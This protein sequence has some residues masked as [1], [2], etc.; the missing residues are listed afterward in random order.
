MLQLGTKLTEEQRIEKAV[1][2]IMHKVP[3]I[4]SLLM[5]GK[6]VVCDKT[7]T[8]CTNG[9]DEWYGRAFIRDLN[10]KQLRFL[11]LHEVYHKMYRHLITWRHLWKKCSNTANRAMDYEINIK[12]LDEFGDFVEWIEGGCLNEKYRGWGTAKIFN[13]IYEER[14]GGGNKSDGEGGAGNGEGNGTGDDSSEGEP[15]DDHDWDSAEEMSED[16]KRE[17]EREIDEAIRQGSIVA[18][19]AGSGGVRDMEELLQPKVNWTE[20]FREFFLATCA[21]NDNSTWRKPKRRF[22]AQDVY[23]PSTFSETI[24]EVLIG[25]DTSGSTFAPGV[26]PAF[27]TEVKSLCDMLTPERVRILYW[28]TAI[29]RAEVYE[30]YELDSLINTTRPEGGGG[31]DVSCVANYIEEHKLDPQAVVLLTDGYLF[32]GW[33]H[34]HHPTLWCVLDNANAQ[35]NNGVTIHINS[36]DM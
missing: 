6:R 25:V 33:G 8:A 28:D 35:P 2:Q 11:V 7:R 23:M 17:L 13:D 18:G 21:G 12:I 22:I 32:G 19:K 10:D 31:T 36:E 3:E 4:G 1:V 5:L 20:P 16:D 14:K 27:M 26:L 29:C 15:F 9:R 34:W 24:G 30:Q